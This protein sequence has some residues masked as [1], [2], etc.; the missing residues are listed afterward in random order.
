MRLSS[1]LSAYM[2]ISESLDLDLVLQSAAK[3]ARE[4]TCAGYSILVTTDE[5]GRIQRFVSAG[6]RPEL[7]QQVL[8]MPRAEEVWDQLRSVENALRLD[9]LRLYLKTRGFPEHRFLATSFL[10]VPVR[11]QGVQLGSLYVIDKQ[12]AR[13]F[14][15]EDEEILSQFSDHAGTSIFN[16]RKY[17]DEQRARTE[18]EA[19][20]DTTPVGVVVF[21]SESGQ[22]IYANQLSRRIVQDLWLPG[23]ETEAFLGVVR[24]RRADG[25]E[26]LLEESSFSRALLD[27]I[28]VRA[29]EII[30]EGPSGHRITVVVNA[31]PL[32]SEQGRVESII[33]TV[34]DMTPL[35]DLERLRAEF[36]G[37]V[38]HELRSPLASIKGCAATVL[39]ASQAIDR[40]EMLQ[41]FRVVT[42]Q[43][44][45][46]RSVISDLLDASRIETGTL[47]VSPVPADVASIVDQAKN[48]FL[49]ANRRHPVR[50]DLQLDLPRILAD[51]QR[52]VQVISN[53]LTNAARCSP[54]SSAIL[55]T[56][57]QEGIHVAVSVTDKG[58][59]IPAV[60]LP[61]VFRRYAQSGR[62]D[63]DRGIGAGL[64]LAICKGIV[65]AHGGRIWVE[66][67]GPESGTRFTFTIPVV[68]ASESNGL[69]QA[70]DTIIPSTKSSATESEHT[71]G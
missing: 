3:S 42:E 16:A 52:I 38:S 61:H 12:S 50:I 18:L 59:G 10:G 5:T 39:E 2:R 13:L 66:S 27:S 69:I 51:R 35:E 45:A 4:L 55:I 7:K 28:P 58:R 65:E 1:L 60:R 34:Q 31:A 22:P 30:L 32:R 9:D 62:E 23:Q 71:R 24:V 64:G 43:A 21:D 33:V 44:E 54:D 8:D 48:S 63:R 57:V 41:F 56:A 6:M 47:S 67:E 26:I 29:E 40:A 15:S 46:M 70:A 25:Q 53:L 14:S 49:N 36:L 68:A 17:R 11:H 20:I 37:I 19:L